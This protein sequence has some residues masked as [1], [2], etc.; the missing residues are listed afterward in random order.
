MGS[1]HN[2]SD[3]IPAW[4]QHASQ[5]RIPT[6]A[7]VWERK[8]ATSTETVQ[9]SLSL[10]LCLYHPCES[11]NTH[12]QHSRKAFLALPRD[13]QKIWIIRFVATSLRSLEKHPQTTPCSSALSRER[14][15]RC[16]SVDLKG[17]KELFPRNP[18][19][20]EINTPLQPIRGSQH[21]HLQA[22]T[23][24]ANPHVLQPLPPFSERFPALGWAPGPFAAFYEHSRSNRKPTMLK[25]HQLPKWKAKAHREFH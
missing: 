15:K 18:H 7:G 23:H 20:F 17:D 14:R 25:Q 2:N 19:K 21:S 3:S 10:E 1:F 12:A 13:G 11:Q 24:R 16:C 9:K 8:R 4:L 22:H 5:I 6:N